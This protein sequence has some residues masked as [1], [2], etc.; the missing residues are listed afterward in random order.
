MGKGGVGK[1]MVVIVIVVGLVERGY[2]VYLS[3]IDFVFY[4]SYVFE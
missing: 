4:L 1:I 2:W 3:I